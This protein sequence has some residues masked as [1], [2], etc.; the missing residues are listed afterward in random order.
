MCAQVLDGHAGDPVNVWFKEHVLAGF[1]P[2]FLN[3]MMPF[4]SMELRPREMTAISRGVSSLISRCLLFE[5]PVDNRHYR[6]L[7]L[8][9]K[10]IFFNMELNYS[11]QAHLG[12]MSLSGLV[13]KRD[14]Y[15]H[16]FQGCNL[17]T[18]KSMSL[19]I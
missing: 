14:V 7:L 3:V 6:Q 11:G 15:Y 12:Q 2:R 9:S 18:C 4:R 5:T 1:L 19:W 16:S 8:K 13:H 17:G 10:R